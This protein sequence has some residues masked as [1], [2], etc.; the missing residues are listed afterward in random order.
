MTK[1]KKNL[2]NVFREDIFYFYYLWILYFRELWSKYFTNKVDKCET[3]K[4]PML[5]M[6]I[7]ETIRAVLRF[8]YNWEREVSRNSMQN[9]NNMFYRWNWS[10]NVKKYLD[11]KPWC[12][13]PLLRD[14]KW[15]TFFIIMDNH[16]GILG[17]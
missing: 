4:F 3:Q 5:R 13:M 8:H 1:I 11:G 6:G 16:W 10:L 15:P 7:F 17:V 2:K 14:N 12:R 9:W